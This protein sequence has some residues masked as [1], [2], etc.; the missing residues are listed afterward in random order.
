MQL[1]N[2]CYDIL[3]VKVYMTPRRMDWEK[4]SQFLNSLYSDAKLLQSGPLSKA[5]SQTIKDFD[6]CKQTNNDEQIEDCLYRNFEL[7]INEV[8]R[9]IRFLKKQHTAMF[10]GCFKYEPEL[11]KMFVGYNE[12]YIFEYV[13]TDLFSVKL[14]EDKL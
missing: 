8:F 2:V 11:Y 3:R 9:V 5:I 13:G 6:Q 7:I 14:D 10:N 4:V 1:T 12:L